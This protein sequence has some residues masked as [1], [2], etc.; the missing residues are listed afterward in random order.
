M[1]EFPFLTQTF[2]RIGFGLAAMAA[3]LW[4]LWDGATGELQAEP[5]VAFLVGCAIW[6]TAEFKHSEEVIYRAS[7]PNDVRVAK[8]LIMYH[9]FQLRIMLN[10]HSF[11]QALAYHYHTEFSA[12]SD[13]IDKKTV[14]LQNRRLRG[15]FDDFGYRLKKFV[16]LMGTNMYAEGEGNSIRLY[17]RPPRY[18]F[19]DW[20]ENQLNEAKELDESANLA[21]DALNNLVKLIHQEVPEAFDEEVSVY[22]R[23]WKSE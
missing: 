5:L 20:T 1:N 7:T 4:L 2:A 14:K 21:W 3:L 9:A 12:F 15:M 8:W 19:G 23:Y 18:S 22:W 16:E 17:V 6:I 10:E 11:R 13:D